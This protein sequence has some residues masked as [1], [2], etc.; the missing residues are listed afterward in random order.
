MKIEFLSKIK[1]FCVFGENT[2]EVIIV[3]KDDSILAFGTN[4]YGCLGLGHN[5]AVKEPEIVEELCDKKII[6]ISYGYYHVLALTKSEKCYSW[7]CNMFGQLGNGTQNDENK[8]KLIKALNNEKIIKISCGACHSLVLTK[9]GE[10]YGFGCNYDGRVG[11]G[12]NEHELKPIKI[13]GFNNKKIVSMACGSFHS[14]ALTDNGEV[15]SWGNKTS[16]RILIRSTAH[17]NKPQRIDLNENQIAKSISCGHSHSLLLTTVG[18]IYAFGSNIFGQIGNG[19]KYNQSCPVK[20]FGSQ[21]FKEIASHHS[22]NISVAKADND[23][24]YVWGECENQ[25]FSTPQKTDIKSIHEI[26]AKYSK[27]KITYTPIHLFCS[28][29][30]FLPKGQVFF[31]KMLKIFNNPK[32]SDLKFKI[33]NKYIYVQKCIIEANCKYFESKFTENARAMRESTENKKRDNEIEIT[34][35]SYGVYY[36]FLKYIYTDYIDI[37]IESALDLLVLAIDYKEEE[38]KFKCVDIIKHNI[39]I[40]N[41]CSL[42][43]LSYRNNLKELKDLCFEFAFEN[44]KQVKETDAFKQMD[45]K[46]EKDFKYKVF[47]KQN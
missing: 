30:P 29:E 45:N 6:D 18:D 2:Q 34:E 1:F 35:Y 40:E 47:D 42:Y 24:C 17:Q 27:N 12:N 7:G 44:L 4:K 26:F 41:V 25:S 8:P 38:L 31:G 46:S 20:I 10:L 32:Y 19:I 3:V 13:I 21:R 37:E 36:S 5:N 28:E 15:Y 22:T 14:L 11:F 16:D 39:T 43:C 9:S 23:F 33:E